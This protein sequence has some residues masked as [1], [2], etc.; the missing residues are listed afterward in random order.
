MPSL[1]YQRLRAIALM[2]VGGKTRPKTGNFKQFSAPITQEHLV[3]S[4]DAVLPSPVADKA[5]FFQR[6]LP[7]V[8]IAWLTILVR[9]WEQVFHS[10]CL[11]F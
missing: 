6:C 3:A 10:D 2:I 11:Y 8:A 5:L 1:L 7:S 9:L 4:R